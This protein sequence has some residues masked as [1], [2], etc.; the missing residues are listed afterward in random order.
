M[1]FDDRFLEE[2]KSRLRPSDVIGKSVK[3]RRQGREYAGLSPFTK[4]KSP[5]FFVN[6]EKGFY[7]CFSSGKHGDII[8]FLQ[9]TER[10]TFA[11]AVERLAA[12]AG[13]SLP[14]VD[15]RAA[16][17]EQKRSSLGDWMELAAAWF[18]S[19][20]RRPVGQAARAYLEKR[21]LPESE[22]SRFRIGFAPNNRTGL[23]DYL[24]AKGAKPG[25]LV[26]A[27]VLIA[28]EDGGQPYDRFRDRIIFPITDSRGKVVSFGGRAMDPNA[29]AKYLN[30]P[31]TSLFHKGRVLYGLFEARKI[32]HAGQSGGEKPPMVVVEGYMDVIACQRAGVP[33]VAAMGTA[34]TEEQMEGLWRLHPTPTL[35]FDGDKAGKRAA[36]RAIDRALPLLKPGRSFLFSMPVGGKDPDDVLREQGPAALKAQLSDAKPF[37]EALF[38]RER[39]LEPFDTPEQRTN[40]KV[41]LRTLAATI[42]D[43]DL[44]HAYKE[45]LLDR[46]DEMRA[47][48]RVKSDASD[49]GRALS[50]ARWDNAPRRP[51]GKPRLEGATAEGRQ[52]AAALHQAPRPFSAA[53]LIAAI[54]DPKVV[55]DRI[56][57]LM[58]QGFG[59]ERLD[60]IA[61]ELVNL[62]L[63]TDHVEAGLLKG[64]L[65][66]AGYDEGVLSSLERAAAHVKALDVA[67]S[68]AQSPEEAIRGLWSQAF[69]LLLRLTA[70]ERA[71]DDAKT[72]LADESDFQTLL[73]LKTERDAVKRLIESGGWTDPA[74]VSQVLH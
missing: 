40:L 25:D 19:E 64:R 57:V 32:L 65:A 71:V 36:D 38:E 6:D 8:S 74:L 35:C 60:A 52:A 20:L 12:E 73:R 5:S 56:E 39:D 43:K 4:E 67:Q 7:H 51:W 66:S 47:A 33:A 24:I 26:D 1:R 69:D 42:A 10:L 72:D 70:L 29:R 44:A 48:R 17:E 58:N 61:Q 14:E 41:R 62:R 16:R 31:E 13:M 46:L 49:A 50:R 68:A 30:G 45:E 11:E 63:E 3:L 28:P 34:L 21:G 55:D 37:V 54:R 53:L 22:W 23:K 2:L 18:E 15:P 27:G 9:E 59:D